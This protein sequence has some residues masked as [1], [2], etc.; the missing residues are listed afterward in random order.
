MR[1][2]DPKR[3]TISNIDNYEN[4]ELHKKIRVCMLI[5]EHKKNV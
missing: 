3:F 4:P 5:Y 1:L 2:A